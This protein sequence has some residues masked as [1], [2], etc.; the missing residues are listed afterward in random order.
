MITLNPIVLYGFF[1]VLK[2]KKKHV[3][4]HLQ[5]FHKLKMKIIFFSNEL[6]TNVQN[7]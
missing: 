1:V 5:E 6:R 7:T 3:R 4:S 2:A